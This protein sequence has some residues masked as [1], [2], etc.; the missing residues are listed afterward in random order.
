MRHGPRSYFDEIDR[1]EIG[2]Q[3]ENG[4]QDNRRRAVRDPPDPNESS[5]S[6]IRRIVE[7]C[8]LE[9]IDL[10]IFITPAHVHQLEIASAIGAWHLIED[11]KRALVRQLAEDALRHRDRPPITLFD[12][13]GYSRVTTEALPPRGS[14]EEMLYYWDSS[15]F[16]AQVGDYVL[17]RLFDVRR[18]SREV[19][20]DFGVRLTNA[21]IESTLAQQRVTQAAYRERFPEEVAALRS[22]ARLKLIRGASL[23]SAHIAIY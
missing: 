22:L 10:R 18:T 14:R 4:P 21:T 7:F 11:G 13:S 5:L 2:F 6:Y 9:G 20:H 12:F 16:K 8:R 3:T 23:V 19:P 17:D 15:H 1:L